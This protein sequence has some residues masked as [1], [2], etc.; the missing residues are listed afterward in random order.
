MQLMLAVFVVVCGI[1]RTSATAQDF[2]LREQ[3][4]RTWKNE[5]VT[6]PL[7]SGQLASVR[8]GAELIGSNGEAIPSQLVDVSG[9]AR[10]A[11]QTTLTPDATQTYRL[12]N[13]TAPNS[14]DLIEED[15]AD[16]LRLGNL[17]IGIALRKT[18]KA[19]EAPIGGIRLRSGIWTAGAKRTGG[20]EVKDYRV[21]LL[22]SGP[23]FAEAACHV[24]FTD[25]GTWSIRFRVLSDEPV[26]LVN[27][28]F[29]APA[30]GEIEMP[31]GSGKFQPTQLL[32]R[33]GMGD[34]GKLEAWT[35]TAGH[36]FTLEPWLRWWMS[37][38]QG[39]WFAVC[40]PGDA[41]PPGKANDL[42]MVGALRPSQWK[43]LNWNG[44]AA[45]LA[46]ELAA[47]VENGIVMLKFP[48]GGGER[49]WMLATPPAEESLVPLKAENR[50][51]SP[52]P[53]EYL[54]KYGDFPLDEVKDYVLDWP[55]DHENYPRLFIQK[56]D[57]PEWRRRLKRD[58]AEVKRWTSQAID[59]YNI[60]SPLQAW[61][62]SEDSGLGNAI[63]R[64]SNEWLGQV[65]DD[66]LL[67]QNSR[68]T[69]G[70]APHMQA[71][72]L[73]PTI[74]LTDAALGC[75]SVTPEMRKRMLARIAFLG[76]AVNREDYWSPARGFSANPNMTTT[77]ALYQ[78]AIA[79]L[80]PSH[81]MAKQWAANGLKELRRELYAWSD[82][83]GGWLEAPHYAMVSFDHILGA[84]LMASNAGFDD[85]VHDERIRKVIEWLAKI[86]TPPDRRT[87][88]FRHFPP[89]GNTY[90]GESSGMFGIVAGLWKDRD[91]EFAANMQWMCEEH[92]S[93]DIGLLGSFG[94]F[95]GYK[96]QL[97]AN[98]VV[99]VAPAY[100]SE[101]FRNTGVVLRNTFASDRE[102]YLHL[103]AGSQHDHYDFDSGS[104][105]LW[106][107]GR[108]LADDFGYIGRHPAQW[109]SLL[110]S[111]AIANDSVMQIESFAP[112]K[113]FDYV[114]GRK[115][116]WQRQI[117]FV[118]DADPLGPTAFL[119]RDS[120]DAETDAT[121]RLWLTTTGI[122]IHD[123]GAT[124]VGED[125]VD[126]DIFVFDPARL[127]L[128]TE[129]TVQKGIGKRDGKEGPMEIRQTALVATLHG[130]TAM[131]TLIFPRL[132]TDPVP[133]VTWFADG[134][135]V[136]LDTP[137]G[138]DYLFLATLH[139]EDEKKLPPNKGLSTAGHDAAFQC[140][141]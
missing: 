21:E 33:R 20:A 27:E 79:S 42:L 56:Q 46:P 47:T 71:V 100:G 125:D 48:L 62:A 134:E 32:Y 72:L 84:F 13:A 85:S 61:F 26:V 98:G 90:W 35:I 25:H 2:V 91:P 38:R 16:Q 58:P 136:K 83:D 109:H 97:K 44:K 14:S 28:M 89:V 94:T 101:W 19:G 95:S 54:I 110:T 141:S 52:L 140:T 4:G 15:E 65:V 103:I 60:E 120:H 77:V 18:L 41:P 75:E 1:V 126:L 132:K 113:A 118:K 68:V 129:S 5:L 102:T 117:A 139:R 59:K 116:V 131:A 111:S 133:T 6:F 9:Q 82:E 93:P 45:Q 23:V 128:K 76:Y 88:G 70:V 78:T 50:K 122:T 31:M 138:T 22:A 96:T 51:I 108:V 127:S 112:N 121:W 130:R 49:N 34:I 64:R 114:L 115:G 57:L 67:D 36:A 63:V 3:L 37:D 40:N 17:H 39:N 30:G 73:L 66:D 124:V 10:I 92:G 12:G 106:G 81:P 55:G 86:S 123:H 24:T 135:G 43:D 8:K 104:I 11:F 107:K 99:P 29:D 53:H 7:N 87:G 105:V 74:N 69:L 80:I 119:I 137:S